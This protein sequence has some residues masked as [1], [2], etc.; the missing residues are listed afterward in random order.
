MVGSTP[1]SRHA[2]L[3]HRVVLLGASNLTR[4][5]ATV[6]STTQL[7]LGEQLDLLI[8]YGHGR[9]YGATSWIPF[10]SLPGIMPSAIWDELAGRPR[11]PTFA[12]V[13]DIG[14]DLLYQFPVARV[15]EWVATCLERLQAYDARIVMTA[16][17]VGN[18][19]GMSERRFRFFRNLF[20]PGSRLQRADL[21]RSV[22]EL[23]DRLRELAARLEIVRI[24]QRTEW[25]GIDPI[26]LR[27]ARWAQAW[28]EILAPWNPPTIAPE[29]P[30]VPLARRGSLSTF[31][32]LRL[33]VP[34]ERQWFGRRQQQPQPALKLAD[35]TQVSLY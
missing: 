12:L 34:H 28:G 14:N 10:R 9:S 22:Y 30:L 33:A 19:P 23:D 6:V 3:R 11:L 21:V 17:P 16:L 27:T 32:R 13:T 8:A 35:G 2:D 1:Q 18:L 31:A 20:T 15:A 24:E 5:V 4:A 29:G 25:Y 26:H 7:L